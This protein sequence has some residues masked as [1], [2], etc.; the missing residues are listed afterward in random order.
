[1]EKAFNF[2]LLVPPRHKLGPVS[3]VKPQDTGLNEENRSFT[4]PVKV[5]RNNSG[6]FNRQFLFYCS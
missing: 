4:A 3:A 2:K 6:I 5:S 1:M